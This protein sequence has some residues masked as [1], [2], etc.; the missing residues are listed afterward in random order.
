MV[1]NN[2]KLYLIHLTCIAILTSHKYSCDKNIVTV[3]HIIIDHTSKNMSK[4]S[5]LRDLQHSYSNFV[6]STNGTQFQ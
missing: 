6:F 5:M 1:K 2:K 3:H 4:S